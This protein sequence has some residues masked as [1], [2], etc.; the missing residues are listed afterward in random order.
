MPRL[1]ALK[2]VGASGNACGDGGARAMAAAVWGARGLETLS[3]V[4]NPAV[5]VAVAAELRVAAGAAAVG[6]RPN[7]EYRGP[8]Q[9]SSG[10]YDVCHVMLSPG[11]DH[12]MTHCHQKCVSKYLCNAKKLDVLVSR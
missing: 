12:G 2:R 3:M 7:T 4:G 10:S 5:G 1:T 8:E 9:G 11:H 6:A